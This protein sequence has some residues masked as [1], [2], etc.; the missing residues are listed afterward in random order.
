MEQKI[1]K[2]LE[3][4]CEEA[5]DYDGNDMMEDGIIDSFMV[6]TLVEQL[7]KV[8]GIIIDAK[9]VICKNFRNKETIIEL[10]RSVLEEGN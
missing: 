10:I 2:I 1:L 5:I 8:F 9:Y 6:V 7:E 4:Y 3:E